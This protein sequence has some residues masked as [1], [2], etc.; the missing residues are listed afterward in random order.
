MVLGTFCLLSKHSFTELR[1]YPLSV[2]IW[3]QWTMW[4]GLMSSIEP[5]TLINC[6][7]KCTPVLW[8]NLFTGALSVPS[9]GL[10]G[11]SR[12]WTFSVLLSFLTT[13]R[14]PQEEQPYWGRKLGAL[15]FWRLQDY[16][17]SAE[18]PRQAAGLSWHWQK[19][20]V[21]HWSLKGSIRDSQVR[22]WHGVPSD[23]TS[24]G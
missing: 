12:R 5:L 8:Q 7:R 20:Q 3:K 22:V 21:R 13:K 4:C 1:P 16:L 2:W 24:L 11:S 9:R 10:V 6:Q 18:N 23:W 15:T 19:A 14:K 17:E